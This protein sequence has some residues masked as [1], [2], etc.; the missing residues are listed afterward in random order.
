MPT[1]LQSQADS[2]STA[3]CAFGPPGLKPQGQGASEQRTPERE[4]AFIVKNTFLEVPEEEHN[5]SSEEDI[6]LTPFRRRRGSS[7][8]RSASEP[9]L[10]QRIDASILEAE[11]KLASHSIDVEAQDEGR[12]LTS[13]ANIQSWSLQ[14]A[15]VDDELLE[16]ASEIPVQQSCFRSTANVYDAA[17]RQS[18]GIQ[19]QYYHNNQPASAFAPVH[20]IVGPPQSEN[21]AVGWPTYADPHS[22]WPCHPSQMAGTFTA[23]DTNAVAAAMYAGFNAGLMAAMQANQPAKF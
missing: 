16:V 23:N 13:N 12:G 14:S 21:S 18:A 8:W 6:G 22:S 11:V 10:P 17:A 7:F 5:D 20:Q 1:L 15:L 3:L 4:S 9:R 2:V 19:Q